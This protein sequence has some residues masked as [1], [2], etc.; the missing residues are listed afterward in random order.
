MRSC[1]RISSKLA[2]AS[3][4]VIPGNCHEDFF[5]IIFGLRCQLNPR[6]VEMC[7][8]VLQKSISVAVQP[9]VRQM[10]SQ[11]VTRVT[12]ERECAR[13][14]EYYMVLTRREPLE[15]SDKC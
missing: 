12:S 6:Y 1:C 10:V 14:L 8:L 3:S 5:T 7:T 11:S 15:L 9:G 13:M 4:R 2:S